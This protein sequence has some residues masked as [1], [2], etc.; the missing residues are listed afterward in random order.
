M[1]TGMFW[2]G[3]KK[4]LEVQQRHEEQ[5]AKLYTVSA[6]IEGKSCENLILD[7]WAQI[8]IVRPDVVPQHCYTGRHRQV[9]GVLQMHKEYPMAKMN[10]VVGEL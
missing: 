9:S 2:I 8:S 4:V 5:A 7:S 3:L 10:I 1:P 6:K